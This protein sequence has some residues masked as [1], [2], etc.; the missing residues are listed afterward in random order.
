MA[1]NE[2]M[3]GQEPTHEAGKIHYPSSTANTSRSPQNPN[4]PTTT[5][6]SSSTASHTPSSGISEELARIPPIF[7]RKTHQ[8]CLE[9]EANQFVAPDVGR[10]RMDMK[11]LRDDLFGAIFQFLFL[12]GY[13]LGSVMIAGLVLGAL[14][15][16]IG[17]PVYLAYRHRVL[18]S[19]RSKYFVSSATPRKPRNEPELLFFMFIMGS[20][21][22]T[23]EML[24]MI[25]HSIDK[26]I[27]TFRR[28]I[29]NEDD[30]MTR[31]RIIA[32]EDRIGR[33]FARINAN[34]GIFD[35]MEIKRARMV[36]QSW[37]STPIS[38]AKSIWSILQA[39]LAMDGNAMNGGTDADRRFPG[40][41]ATNGPGT[42][43][44]F[45]AVIHYLKMVRF[46]PEDQFNTM[47]VESFARVRSL[48]FTGKLI[49][50]TNVADVFVVQHEELASRYGK[51]L[52]R[53]LVVAPAEPAVPFLEEEE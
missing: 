19:R 13:L 20:G 8:E 39:L 30:V 12:I 17:L 52:C 2:N 31:E 10:G 28:Y 46:L 29:V 50:W 33:R 14:A 48:S 45:L 5:Q 44:L 25:E 47:F 11:A 1:A 9:M 21:G 41:V 3:S 18:V 15:F 7:R 40:A 51:I 22:H 32:L 34:P 36:H 42:G 38:A 23:S 49:H 27:V 35:I 37:L 53:D 16:F 6:S 4:S 43:F 26:E 24:S